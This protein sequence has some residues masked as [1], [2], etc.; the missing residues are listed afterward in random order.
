MPLSSPLPLR[1][2]LV[3]PDRVVLAP[4]TNTQSHPDGTLSDAEARWLVRR[5][6]DGF[7]TVETCAT[8]V[9]EEGK[10]WVGQ[11]GLATAAQ[12]ASVAPL[13]AA[14]RQAG[15]VGLV[16]LHHAG[17]KATCAP[18][19]LSTVDRPEQ[20]VRGA[21][22]GD[23]ARVVDDY[24]AAARR[25]ERAGFAGVEVHGAN[26]YLF[27]QFLAPDTNPRSDAY[28]GSL[29][30]RA[31][32]LRETVRAVRAATAP[33]FAVGVRISPVDARTRRG[34]LLDDSLQV[35]AWMAE[36]G[37]D[38]VHL[39]LQQA[40]GAPPFEPGRAAVVTAFRERLPPSVAVWT[41]GGIWTADEAE[42]A[43]AAGG[44]A[45]VVGKAGIVHPDWPM[46]APRPGF[47]PH[48][49]PWTLDQLA[50]VDVS[51]AFRTYL[52]RFPGLVEGGAPPA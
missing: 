13:A 17:D 6:Q 40:T 52:L 1:C 21:T 5:A 30:G 33:G 38:F 41:V 35:G 25:A 42:E 39:S 51:E 23:L 49:P 4:L 20:G 29:A 2:G 19:R 12:E 47:V 16:Q 11:L 3:L 46:A 28:G 14:L 10:A 45:V 8:Y 44:D 48:R 37:V 18:V 32:L 27:T 43:L 15:T 31:R 50:A 36:D 34:I 22:P 7:G 24:V 9:S 26:G